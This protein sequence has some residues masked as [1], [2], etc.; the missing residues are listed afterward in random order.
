MIKYHLSVNGANRELFGV[1]TENEPYA[2]FVGAAQ[3][4][5]LDHVLEQLSG[6]ASVLPAAVNTVQAAFPNV[7]QTITVPPADPWGQ[8]PVQAYQQQQPPPLPA[9]AAP[10]RSGATKVE[11]GFCVHG[12]ATPRASKPGAAKEWRGY[13]CPAPKGAPDQCEPE[14]VR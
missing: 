13:F 7:T 5:G 12:P 14:F 4:A 6:G 9:A 1:Q 2:A 8:P 3:E 11:N 10:Q